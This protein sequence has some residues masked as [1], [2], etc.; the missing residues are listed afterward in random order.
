[1]STPA[2]LTADIK[3][4]SSWSIFMGVITAALGVFLIAYPPVHS[5][6]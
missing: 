4:R 5:S 2:T 1:M 6:L 3:K